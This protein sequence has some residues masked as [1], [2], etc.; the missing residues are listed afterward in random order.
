GNI[1][2]MQ[3]GAVRLANGSFKTD[4]ASDPTLTDAQL[5]ALAASGQEL[6]YTAVPV[7]SGTRIGIDRDLDGCLDFDDA[8]PADPTNCG[9][10]TTTTTTIGSTTTTTTQPAGCTT[11][12][13]LDPK[14][15]VGVTARND[16]GRIRAKMLIDLAS[17]SGESVTVSLSDS[18]TPA[19]AIQSV[20]ALPP[21]GTSGKRFRF[22]TSSYGVQRVGMR[23][24]TRSHPGQFKL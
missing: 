19:I 12:P 17:Y 5:R 1:G 9:A 20:G 7:G 4:R 3:R 24:V 6:T 16:L 13:V 14:A 23:D 10:G 2:G 21:I 15:S 22:T 8:S 18:D 11:V